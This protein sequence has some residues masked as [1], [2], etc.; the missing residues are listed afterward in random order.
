MTDDDLQ[1]PGAAQRLAAGRTRGDIG[2]MLREGLRLDDGQVLW[3]GGL[4]FMFDAAAGDPIPDMPGVVPVLACRPEHF[5]DNA[6]PGRTDMRDAI[7]LAS[8]FAAHGDLPLVLDDL[9][10][11][12]TT[13]VLWAS[14]IRGRGR[15][16]PGPGFAPNGRQCIVYIGPAGNPDPALASINGLLRV[17]M[18]N[19]H[20]RNAGTFDPASGRFPA[21]A[22][23]GDVFIACSAGHVDGLD[24]REYDRIRAETH[25]PPETRAS[26][27]RRAE[28]LA[29]VV[30]EDIPTPHLDLDLEIWNAD[31]GVRVAGNTERLRLRVSGYHVAQLACEERTRKRGSPDNNLWILGSSSCGQLFYSAGSCVSKIELSQCQASLRSYALP[32]IEKDSDRTLVVAGTPRKQMNGLLRVRGKTPGGAHVVFDGLHAEAPGAAADGGCIT[33]GNGTTFTGMLSISHGDGGLVLAETAG[34][35]LQY[36]VH[37]Q[38]GG[39][40]LQLGTGRTAASNIDIRLTIAQPHHHER[41]LV[42]IDSRQATNGAIHYAGHAFPCRHLAG[43]GLTVHCPGEMI[44]QGTAWQNPGQAA[45]RFE[46]AVPRAALRAYAEARLAAPGMTALQAENGLPAIY[47]AGSGAWCQPMMSEL[48]L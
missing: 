47:D 35:C 4:A 20:G 44:R 39:T 21:A 42:A 36:G 12:Q 29:A 10:A 33:I 41:P 31:V 19:V 6:Q 43:E 9:Y 28:P 25:R 37:Q 8:R 27:W 11:V 34:G 3:A 26:G 13:V 16:V 14:E 40:V 7:V 1:P 22:A 5:R 2:R 38:N 45:I 24:F 17:D 15:I 18:A 32:A 46:G 48:P 23:A 30:I